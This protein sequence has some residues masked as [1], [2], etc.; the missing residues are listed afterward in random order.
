MARTAIHELVSVRSGRT[1]VW[2][3]TGGYG[4]ILVS[5]ADD[6]IAALEA[7]T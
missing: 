1:A 4:E 7:V 3:I 5:A 6:V 2:V